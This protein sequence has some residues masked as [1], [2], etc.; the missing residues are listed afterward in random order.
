MLALVPLGVQSLSCPSCGGFTPVLGNYTGFRQA[1]VN[2]MVNLMSRNPYMINAVRAGPTSY[3]SMNSGNMYQIPQPLRPPAAHGRK[4]A[5]LCGILYK[6]HKQALNG[7]INDVMLMKK[8]LIERMGFPMASILVLTEEEDRSRIPTK[9]NIRAAMRWLVQGCQGG[10]S[11]VFFYSGHG[12][13]MKDQDGDELDGYDECLLPL[14]YEFEGKILDD[15]INATIVRPLPKDAKLHAIIDTCFS[16]TFLDL[17]N[18]C[19]VTRDGY[20]KWDDH[21]VKNAFKGTSGGL[22]ISISACEDH[23]N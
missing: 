5:F 10:D 17:T 9:Q 6:G 13:Q 15:E 8:L 16:G 11:L 18:V 2:G 14:D 1:A 4:R 19:R 23:Q 20:Y 12:S 7:S 21:R 3:P 22:A